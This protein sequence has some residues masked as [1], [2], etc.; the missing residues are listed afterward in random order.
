MTANRGKGGKVE[1]LSYKSR[2]EEYEQI[3]ERFCRNAKE[4]TAIL[5]RDADCGIDLIA[6]LMK[7]NISFRLLQNSTTFFTNKLVRDVKDFIRLALNPY[8]ADAFMKIYYKISGAK[9]NKQAAG[10]IAGYAKNNRKSILEA[11]RGNKK[12]DTF[13]DHIERIH[14]LANNP[15]AAI[16]YIANIT[17]Q[18]K[19]PRTPVTL[20]ILTQYVQNIS[21]LEGYF[22]RLKNEIEQAS[23][24][25]HFAQ[26]TLSTIHSAKGMEFHNVI[27][28]DVNDRFIPHCTPSDIEENEDKKDLYQEERRLFYVAMTRA[29]DNLYIAHVTQTDSC[30]VNELFG[31]QSRETCNNHTT[32]RE[33]HKSYSTSYS[34]PSVTKG[35]SSNIII[36]SDIEFRAA[37][38]SDYT[39][40]SLIKHRF[41]GIGIITDI[42]EIKEE[43]TLIT[44]RFT[45][46]RIDKLPLELVVQSELI[47]LGSR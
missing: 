35:P 15:T 39:I 30:F 1:L 7:N 20:E 22:D 31:R 16:R 38:V 19:T 14:D 2:S 23:N 10:K 11:I 32:Y 17:D 4:E 33:R 42:T 45:D 37:S 29:K 43:R 9:Y 41:L 36:P 26:L 12:G 46:N 27:I 5:Y 28:L 40:N 3:Y 18:G 21:E 8:D 6:M 47:L 25:S 34:S 13:A 24:S 44:I